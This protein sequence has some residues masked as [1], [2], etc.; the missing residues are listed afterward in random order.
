LTLQ[1]VQRLVKTDLRVL[2]GGGA[3]NRQQMQILLDAG[4]SALSLDAA[5]W[6][7]TSSALFD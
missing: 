7:I 4:I 3:F 6:G 2:A 1:A 5:L